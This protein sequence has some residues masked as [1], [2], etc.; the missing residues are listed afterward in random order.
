MKHIFNHLEEGGVVIV[1]HLA[2]ELD[3]KRD[4]TTEFWAEFMP[5]LTPSSVS[6]LRKWKY[7]SMAV[8]LAELMPRFTPSS[9][10][11]LRKW[12]NRR[13]YGCVFGRVHV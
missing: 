4:V 10:S 11:L 2:E 7:G 6:L 9:V 8:F 12:K 1:I 5:K 3:G 13:F